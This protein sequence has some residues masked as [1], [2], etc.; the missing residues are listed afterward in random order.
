MN[1]HRLHLDFFRR[2]IFWIVRRVES[3]TG[4]QERS[5][6]RRQL[7]RNGGCSAPMEL[8]HS[9]LGSFR[10]RLG[11]PAEQLLPFLDVSI[12]MGILS[13]LG[14]PRVKGGAFCWRRLWDA[15]FAKGATPLTNLRAGGG[16]WAANLHLHGSC[17][18]W[19]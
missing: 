9:V 1:P 8:V 3:S 10:R 15:D 7:G 13:V 11:L 14:L 18:R 2:T 19:L 6:V 16:A 4:H 5:E 12:R 17:A